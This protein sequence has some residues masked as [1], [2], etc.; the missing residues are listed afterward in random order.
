LPV[1]GYAVVLQQQ[2][3]WSSPLPVAPG[4]HSGLGVGGAGVGGAGVGGTGVGG[5]G[6]GAGVGMGHWP[7]VKLSP[8]FATSLTTTE[9]SARSHFVL[10]KVKKTLFRLAVRRGREGQHNSIQ[11]RLDTLATHSY[12]FGPRVSFRQMVLSFSADT[13]LPATANSFCGDGS[14]PEIVYVTTASVGAM[15]PFSNA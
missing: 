5:A 12:D 4:T 3:G 6:V 14:N 7:I 13:T 8:T 9:L 15:Q 1:E 2:F 10:P 11:W